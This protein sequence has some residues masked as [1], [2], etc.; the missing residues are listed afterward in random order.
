MVAAFHRTV[1]PAAVSLFCD[2]LLQCRNVTDVGALLG[3]AA[4]VDVWARLVSAPQYRQTAARKLLAMGAIDEL[5][6]AARTVDLSFIVPEIGH[7]AADETIRLLDAI[8]ER[9]PLGSGHVVDRAIHEAASEFSNVPNKGDLISAIARVLENARTKMSAEDFRLLVESSGAA[10]GKLV[11]ELFP[12]GRPPLVVPDGLSVIMDK[13]PEL[14]IGQFDVLEHLWTNQEMHQH[15]ERTLWRFV[16]DPPEPELLKLAA[17]LLLT[18]PRQ[19]LIP[20]SI[21][22]LITQALGYD[23]FAVNAAFFIEQCFDFVA[24]FIDIAVWQLSKHEFEGPE[25]RVTLAVEIQNVTQQVTY[26]KGAPV[27]RFVAFLAGTFGYHPS[28]MLLYSGGNCVGPEKVIRELIQPLQIQLK[29]S[30]ENDPI[31]TQETHPIALFRNEATIMKM[32]KWLET[33]AAQYVYNVLIQIPT[34]SSYFIR[35]LGDIDPKKPFLFAY[36]LDYL[37]KS[38]QTRADKDIVQ[39]ALERLLIEQFEDLKPRARYLLAFMVN[40]ES[41]NEDLLN[42]VLASLCRENHPT[43]FTRIARRLWAIVGKFELQVGH[44]VLRQILSVQKAKFASWAL[45]SRLIRGQPFE[46]LWSV[47]ESSADKL[48][49]LPILRIVPIPVEFCP[50]VFEALLPLFDSFDSSILAIMSEMVHMW[51]DF[52][53]RQIGPILIRHCVKCSESVKPVTKPALDLLSTMMLTDSEFQKSVLAAISETI[54][55]TGEWNYEPSDS[56]K[57]CRVG[58][59]NLGA[60][61]YVNLVVEQLFNIPIVRTFFLKTVFPDDSLNAFHVVFNHLQYSHRKSVDMRI[62]T[63]MWTDW[64]GAPIAVRIQQDVI[65]FLML[66]FSRLELY[67]HIHRLFAG[68]TRTTLTGEHGKLNST[69]RIELFTTLPVDIL[70][71]NSLADSLRLFAHSETIENYKPEGYS[72]A[73]TVESQHMITGLPPYLFMQLK[74]FEYSIK[75]SNRT[76]IDERFEFDEEIDFRPFVSS[77]IAETHYKLIGV[78]IHQGAAE[79]GHYSNYIWDGEQWLYVNDRLVQVVTVAEMRTHS[80]GGVPEGTCA[81]LLLYERADARKEE[82]EFPQNDDEELVKQITGDNRSLDIDAVYF[83]PDFAQFIISLATRGILECPFDYYLRVL[84]HS[85]MLSQMRSLTDVLVTRPQDMVSLLVVKLDPMLQLLCTSPTKFVRTNLLDLIRGVLSQNPPATDFMVVFL[86]DLAESWFPMVIKHWRDSFDFF[87]IFWDF[88]HISQEHKAY[89]IENGLADSL[90]MFI[91]EVIPGYVLNRGNS[92]SQERFTNLCNMSYLLKCLE[93]FDCDSTILFSKRCLKWF[94][95]GEFHSR[96]LIDLVLHFNPNAIPTFDRF[97]EQA[98]AIP[99]EFLIS[100]LIKFPEFKCPVRW[101]NTQFTDA[102]RQKHLLRA[103]ASQLEGDAS[104]WPLFFNNQR[105]ILTHL[106][107]SPVVDVRRET[108]SVFGRLGPQVPDFDRLLF[109]LVELIPALSTKL[110]NSKSDI[111]RLICRM[112]YSPDTSSCNT[113]PTSLRQSRT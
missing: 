72:T 47:F 101:L 42:V 108:V 10:L 90:I 76:K 37:A 82:I 83:S 61:C 15:I 52:P 21:C 30:S 71:Q 89:L 67:P 59:T 40:T 31:F 102:A 79:A 16:L 95:G 19:D 54:P 20:A 45:S 9:S 34:P 66:L 73:I 13:V 50:K 49:K 100:E 4:P 110:Y 91:T 69:Q 27:A 57:V 12:I 85:K 97:L 28:S 74:R 112:I 70:G 113:S 24:K 62:F 92:V 87:R 41:R 68:E 44:E 111:R 43:F 17:S 86:L 6:K 60:T 51:A 88:A 7:R 18:F 99:S 80:Y 98:E 58:L 8:W 2:V 107:F 94:V 96:C 84:G 46:S 55:D 93:I 32:F 63:A 1:L 5:A 81:Y 3:Q 11:R 77:D 65:E 22:G 25:D 103:I 106:L 53:I 56:I 14:G 105:E 104:L 64:E 75:D 48:R 33:D 26:S 23:E 35:E 39:S 36:Q 109:P 29:T 38:L 78:I